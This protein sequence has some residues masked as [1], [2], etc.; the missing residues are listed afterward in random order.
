[1]NSH[2]YK[3]N[4]DPKV[5]IGHSFYKGSGC[6]QS[7][8]ECLSRNNKNMTKFRFNIHS[9]MENNAKGNIWFVSGWEPY[10]S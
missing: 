1:M 7:V 2:S 9:Y 3:S 4:P 10:E 5:H 6:K 8:V